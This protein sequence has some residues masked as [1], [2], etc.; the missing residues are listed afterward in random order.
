MKLTNIFQHASSQSASATTTESSFEH[1]LLSL[2]KLAKVHDNDKDDEYCSAKAIFEAHDI[3]FDAIWRAGLLLVKG[4]VQ[5]LEQIDQHLCR[6]MRISMYIELV[7]EV[8]KA[9]RG[10]DETEESEDVRKIRSWL[11]RFCKVRM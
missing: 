11:K 5:K 2:A 8:E 6:R 7:K 4:W 9:A 3:A 10:F 1:H